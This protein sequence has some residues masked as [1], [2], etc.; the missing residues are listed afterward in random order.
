MIGL[1]WETLCTIPSHFFLDSRD[2]F[3]YTYLMLIYG[4]LDSFENVR[5]DS[6]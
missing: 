1:V 5:I 4:I 6:L 3:T 2:D